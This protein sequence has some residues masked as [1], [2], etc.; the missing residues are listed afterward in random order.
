MDHLSGLSG[1]AL[2][3]IFV[4]MLVRE[5]LTWF[6]KHMNKTKRT[7]LIDD[8]GQMMR[9]NTKAIERVSDQL[10]SHQEILQKLIVSAATMLEHQRMTP[11]MGRERVG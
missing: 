8:L 4:I 1:V 9:E 10:E 6:S 7:D 5:L 3:G 11:T 2:P